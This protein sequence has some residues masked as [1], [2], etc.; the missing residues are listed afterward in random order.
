MRRAVL[1]CGHAL[2]MLATLPAE[3]VPSSLE[4]ARHRIGPLLCTP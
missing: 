1:H 3:S 4:L 2:T